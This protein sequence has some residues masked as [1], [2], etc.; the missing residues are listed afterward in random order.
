MSTTPGA[1][2]TIATGLTTPEAQRL[3]AQYGRNAVAEQRPSPLR[4]LAGK[5]WAP[6][7]WMLEAAV[8]LEILLG[9]NVEAGVIAGLLVFN[10]ALSFFQEKQAQQA[11][12]LLRQQLTI[13][14]RVMRDGAWQR[15]PAENLVPGD[16]IHLRVGDLVPADAR[17][18]SGNILVDHS[19]VT[20][21]S[22]PSDAETGA[23]VYTG[24][25][26]KRGEA[27]AVVTATG[28]RTYFGKTAELVREAKTA[29]HLQQMI[30]TVV[31]Y[32]VVFDAAL[33][34][35]V[36]IYSLS[37]GIGLSDI[38]P[39]CVMLLVASIPVA[40]P[41]TFTLASAVGTRELA[42]RGV[43]VSRLSAIEE[44]AAMD[45]LATDKTGTL[46]R[47]ELSVAV[48]KPVPP[49]SAQDV[50]RFAAL[51]SDEATQDPID[52]AILRAAPGQIPKTAD[53]AIQK[54]IPFEPSTKYSEAWVKRSADV[55]R[56]VKGAPAAIA[57]LIHTASLPDEEHLAAEGYRVL[58][59][60]A[61]PEQAMT[62]AGFIALL[63]P[64]RDDS[65]A[66]VASLH[67]LGIR[68]LMITGDGLATAQTV[69]AK[70]GIDGHSC[71][72]DRIRTDPQEAAT[73]CDVFAGVFPEDKFRLVEVLQG[74]GHTVGMT[75]DGVNDA[76]ALKQAE[77]GIAV[78]N[79]TDVAKAAAS[80]VLTK[81]GLTDVVSAI[82][83]SRRIYQRMLTYTLNKIIKTI[84][85]AL[86]LS[87]GVILMRT[88]V[89][90]PLLIVLL[91]FTND[92]VTMSIATD[93]VSFSQRPDHWDIRSLMQ[94]AIPLAVL[95]V[96]FSLSMLF[97]GR[98]LL[99]FSSKQ[100]QTLAFLTLVFGGQ[101]TVYLVR[102]RNHFWRS[103]PSRW[104]LAASVADLS[105][106]SFLAVNGVWM[107]PVP[108]TVVSG[109]LG[110]VIGYLFII[111]F[112][113]IQILR[114]SSRLQRRSVLR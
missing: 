86:F 36:F 103:P 25:V 99:S 66:L 41:A 29:G 42:G 113:K 3:L 27:T 6:V 80:I 5:F 88:L 57:A 94:T 101:G 108:A 44:A 35:A 15:L 68:V 106:V 60:A 11:L 30:F 59:V 28:S 85:I 91:L 83:T 89:I 52:L 9:K 26:V 77:V 54:F 93:R 73:Q 95:I 51:A 12:A 90:T 33:A 64:P 69:A 63:D 39:F 67:N 47:N 79:A 20:G 72:P 2:P 96:T 46:T 1:N 50:L 56:I 8:V 7:P 53:Y 70:V 13:Q 17:V 43:L 74:A 61:G 82:E 24:G 48:V 19:A 81:P 21:E 4:E 65:A 84:E 45:A 22:T 32:L 97:V 92:F 110:A 55:I 71:L 40:L 10:A 109:L 78:A 62:I 49:H 75:G 38:L 114:C 107:A 18:S 112:L 87:L 16:L 76:P 104:M 100:I 58:A 111:D 34:I 14:V 98:D 105:I 37:L 23:T 102:E 31:Q